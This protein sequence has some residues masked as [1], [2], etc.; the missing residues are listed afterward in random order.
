MPE[1]DRYGYWKKAGKM[2]VVETLLKIWK[3][4]GHRVLMFTQSKQMLCILEDFVQKQGYKYLKLDG[5]TVIGSRQPIINR[6]NQ[7]SML[8][9]VHSQN[10]NFN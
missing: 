10:N 6:F 2:I 1:E 8:H 9:L 3:K 4:Q 5:T 7:V